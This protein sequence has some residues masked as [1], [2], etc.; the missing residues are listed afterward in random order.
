MILHKKR[1]E[2]DEALSSE[3]LIRKDLHSK[4][5]PEFSGEP[6]D[7]N[8]SDLIEQAK[9]GS[10]EAF[11]EIVRL[12]EKFV[13]NTACRAL[14]TGGCKTDDAD[15]IAQDSFIKA[16]R[17]LSSFRGDCSFSTWIFRI[18]VNTAKDMMRS[19]RGYKNTVSLS[20]TNDD[21]EIT[22]W[23]IPVTDGDSLPEEAAEKKELISEVRQAI[24]LLPED[25]RKVIVMR[26]LYDLPYSEIASALGVETG[27]VKSRISRG[28][29]NLKSILKKGNFFI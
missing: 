12:Y 16:W 18:T 26:D 28:R 7:I 2:A 10:D 22:Q 25:Q 14:S 20:V 19:K 21:D 8:V 9:H 23:D 5:A 27:T 29:A 1:T 17:S 6:P 4:D 15:D 3:E 13:F 24:E 11:G